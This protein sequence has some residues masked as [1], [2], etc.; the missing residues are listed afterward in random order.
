M[1]RRT[2]V[3]G[4]IG[5]AVLAAASAGLAAGLPTGAAAPAVTPSRRKT[6]KVVRQNLADTQTK[7]GTLGYGAAKPVSCRLNGT[8][9]HVTAAGTIVQRGQALFRV[10]DLPVVLMYGELPAYRPLSSGRKGN[11][12]KQ[13]TANLKALGFSGFTGPAIR[14]WQKSL[15]LEQ[16][17][18]VEP[19][20]VIYAPGPV[21]VD[22][23]SAAIGDPATGQILSFTGTRLVVAATLEVGDAR[24]APVGAGVK[25]TL[26]DGKSVDGKVESVTTTVKPGQNGA[27]PTT[28]LDVVIGLGDTTAGLQRASVKV[29][30]TAS[31]REQVLTVPVAAL[32]ALREGG[33]G[34]E[35]LESGTGKIMAVKTGLFAAGRVEVSGDGLAEGMTVGMPA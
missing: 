12:V 30:F 4:G 27:D 11:D 7:N 26:P 24:L 9:T 16:T 22:S 34:V 20:R 32:L 5:A 2:F 6:A 10:D 29:A 21:R 8:V 1:N 31:V 35:V 23:V 18:V 13:F 17:G 15:G 33:Y 25:V 3:I 14:K 28:E 19:G